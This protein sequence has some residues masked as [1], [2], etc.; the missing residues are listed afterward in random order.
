MRVHSAVQVWRE[1]S[2][3]TKARPHRRHRYRRGLALAEQLV[4]HRIGPLLVL[5]AACSDSGNTVGDLA[6]DM[7]GIYRVTAF[8]HNSTACVPG[9]DSVLGADRFAVISSKEFF[10]QTMVS[11]VSCA[12]VTDC[13]DKAAREAAGESFPI[14]FWFTASQVGSA[15]TLV[16]QIAS[17]GFED[18]GIC[19]Q[20]ELSTATFA[21]TATGIQIENAITIADDYP[22]TSEGFCSTTETQKA[23]QG[24]VLG[25]RGPHRGF[26]RG[27]VAVVAGAGQVT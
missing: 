12:S 9:G 3:T 23:A 7:T 10:G 16:G 20:G 25:A 17:T 11:A 2:F 22:V 15:D 19:T 1:S 24:S 13:R 26:R 6:S 27:A 5:L 14:E 4:M 8:T 21:L 18:G